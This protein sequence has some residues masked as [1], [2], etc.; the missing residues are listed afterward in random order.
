MTDSGIVDEVFIRLE[1]VHQL[2]ATATAE[3]VVV[4]ATDTVARMQDRSDLAVTL[5]VDHQCVGRDDGV[6]QLGH[7]CVKPKSLEVQ[8]QRGRPGHGLETLGD[9]ALLAGGT[10]ELGERFGFQVVL[11]ALGDRVRFMVG[12]Q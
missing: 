3:C 7:V 4:S 2:A 1:F 9:G 8:D 12:G 6:V 5:V 10:H 11:Y